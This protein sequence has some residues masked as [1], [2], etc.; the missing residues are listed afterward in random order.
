MNLFLFLLLCADADDTLK[1]AVSLAAANQLAEAERVLREGRTAHPK[2]ARFEVELA[3]IAWRQKHPDEAK[4]H[5]RQALR[6]DPANAY[7]SEFLGTVY[8]LDGN[9]FAA[10]K[11]LNRLRRPVLGQVALAPDP[12]LRAELV[13]RLVDAS[14]GQ[15]L[16]MRRLSQTEHNLARLRL[17]PEPRYELA[18]R[19]NT[20]DFTVRAP[21]AGSPIS[22]VLGR[23][24]PIVR[25]LPY[26]QLNFD[27]LNLG[28]R[29]ISF[30]SLGRWDPDKR[31]IAA[32]YRVPGLRSAYS[33][34]AD[35]RDERWNLPSQTDVGVRSATL[36]GQVEFE[37]GNGA[38]WTPGLILSRHTFRRSPFANATLAE[39]RNRFD[40]PRW[41]WPERRVTVDT[42]L[43]AR[44]G[45]VFSGGRSRLLG[46]EFDSTLRW[47]PQ[48]KDDA[49]QVK[50]R[51]RGA[52]LTG[53]LPV[54]ALY[55]TAIERD[56][57]VWLRGHA[58]TRDGRKG[59]APMGTRYG[60]LQTGAS[61]RVFKM[62]FVRVDAGP[63]FDVGNVGG[64]AGW[65]SRGFLYDTGVQAEVT[66]LGGFRVSFVY[67]RDLRGGHH[68]FYATAILR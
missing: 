12:P 37:L 63:F 52:A 49:Y 15:L 43:T 4:S 57:D 45:S 18:P 6:L 5:L 8:L 64:G 27:F 22:G 36:G 53:Q 13:N 54:D 51:L 58:G 26:Q 19:G 2:D 50:A 34:W 68:V 1:R 38:V 33:L 59:N 40:L 61:R 20:Y 17:F 47:L 23:L 44:A 60:V 31:R 9:P 66:A 29:A 25:G 24:L 39:I 55:M 65:G 67:G 41:R 46:A 14:S 62:P 56:N 7:A 30:T 32:T 21:A 16:T 10:V 42:S 28:Q 3:G 11:Y 48:A 35:L